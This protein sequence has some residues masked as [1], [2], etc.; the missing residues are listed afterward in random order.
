MRGMPHRDDPNRLF[1]F[2]SG[3]KD[4]LFGF[5][6]DARGG[7]LPE[8][9]GPW[10]N[11]GVIRGD[12]KPPHGLSRSAIETGIAENGFQLWRK[13]ASSADAS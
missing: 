10:T 7:K 3:S 8:K 11:V 13:K 4:L 1:M 12:Q 2:R 9:F 5:A 6:S